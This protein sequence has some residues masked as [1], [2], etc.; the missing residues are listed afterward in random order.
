MYE[1]KDTSQIFA[2]TCAPPPTVF[3]AKLSSTS[4]QNVV[5]CGTFVS[6]SFTICFLRNVSKMN[7][8]G[9]GYLHYFLMLRTSS[10]IL[11]CL[12]V[13]VA[14]EQNDLCGSLRSGPDRVC[15]DSG[16]VVFDPVGE[17]AAFVSH[18]SQWQQCVRAH[19]SRFAMP[20][21]S[22]V[23]KRLRLI[24]TLL[25]GSSLAVRDTN[26]PAGY[27]ATC[28]AGCEYNPSSSTAFR[29]G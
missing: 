11:H 23:T 15:E 27:Q 22:V 29:Y 14:G 7:S 26:P 18:G 10:M 19:R 21:R 25:A 17:V 5:G 20:S 1:S 12:L 9:E 4:C 24:S 16:L 3:E 13:C 6:R 28:S 8:Y 2:S